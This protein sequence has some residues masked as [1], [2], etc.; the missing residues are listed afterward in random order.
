MDVAIGYH[1]SAAAVR[2]TLAALGRAGA[3][4]VAVR[5]DLGDPRAAQRLVT[6]AARALGGLDVLVN[7][8]ALFGALPSVR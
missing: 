6:T 4:A 8:A 5:A 2:T 3:H 7:S 1:R